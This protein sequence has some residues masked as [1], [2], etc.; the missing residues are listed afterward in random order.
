MARSERKPSKIVWLA[1]P[2]TL[3][4]DI[5]EKSWK[6]LGVREYADRIRSADHAGVRYL[7]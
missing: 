6:E 4:D 5:F 7:V 3:G 1:S 2:W